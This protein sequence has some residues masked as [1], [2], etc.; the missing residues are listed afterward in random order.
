MIDR[1]FQKLTFTVPSLQLCRAKQF[2]LTI[3]I[4]PSLDCSNLDPKISM[5]KNGKHFRTVKQSLCNFFLPIHWFHS[6]LWIR[7]QR[8]SISNLPRRT[9]WQTWPGIMLTGCNFESRITNADSTDTV[10]NRKMKGPLLIGFQKELA[11]LLSRTI[12]IHSNYTPF[13]L[14]VCVIHWNLQRF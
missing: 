14:H 7:E 13:H 12:P 2:L 8:S 10:Y 11:H 1:C 6:W 9:L 4:F 3:S 5:C